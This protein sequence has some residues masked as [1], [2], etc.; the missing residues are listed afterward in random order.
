MSEFK[1]RVQ[2]AVEKHATKNLPKVKRKNNNP[3][4]QLVELIMEY[5][6]SVGCSAHVFESKSTFS[7]ITQRYIAQSIV[8]GH[9]DVAGCL[10]NGLALYIEVKTK[11]KLKTLRP[12]QHEFLVD[13]ISH[14]AFAVCVDS[15]DMLKEYL[16]AF[17][18]SENRKKYLLSILPVP[19]DKNKDQEE[20]PLF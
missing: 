14:N 6:R 19:Y 8:P 12:K 5:L 7:P 1:K 15:V 10:P 20:G 18:I 4:E 11:G 3:E 2:A 17:K 9:C 13:K 16:E